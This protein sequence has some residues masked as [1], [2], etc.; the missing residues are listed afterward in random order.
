MNLF[1]KYFN[2]ILVIG[3]ILVVFLQ[4]NCDNIIEEPI[5][6]IKYDT[7]YK[8]KVDT[9]YK[10]SV[11]LIKSITIKEVPIYLQP[12]KNCDSL[13]IQYKNLVEKHL[14][15]NIYRDT[16]QIEDIGNLT[17][18]DTVQFNKLGKR[19]YFSNYKIPTVIKT[20]EKES[21]SKIKLYYGGDILLSPI[22]TIVSPGLILNTKKDNI[23][24]F[25]IGIDNN[26]NKYFT[27]GSYWKLKLK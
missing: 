25:N 11:K 22:N 10:D 5:I 27:I 21:P 7:I 17:I 15:K 9:V 14:T 3:L 20:I 16:I 2:T 23:Y 26:L 12:S 1:K 19:T 6:K 24:K 8:T 13:N 18:V 4:R